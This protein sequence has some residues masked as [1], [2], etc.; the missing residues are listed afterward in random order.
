MGVSTTA[1]LTTRAQALLSAEERLHASRELAT[2]L[3][4]DGYATLAEAPLIL[5]VPYNC[6]WR[7]VH[8]GAIPG[9]RR[10]GVKWLIPLRY[11][12]AVMD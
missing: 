12:D 6:I 4:T 5:R 9:A 2:H 7:L 10:I 11:L 3:G 8:K 1:A